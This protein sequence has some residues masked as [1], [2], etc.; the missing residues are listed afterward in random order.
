PNTPPVAATRNSDNS[1]VLNTWQHVAATWDG[2]KN[3]GSIHIYVNGVPSDGAAVDGVGLAQSDAATPLPIG[4]HPVDRARNFDGAID[5][6]RVYNR[7]LTP[8]EIQSLV[9]GGS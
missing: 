8:A 4:N 2:T 9:N 6:V 5:G 1:I 3:A 7:V